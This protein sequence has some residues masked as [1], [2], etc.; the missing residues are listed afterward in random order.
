VTM[1]DQSLLPGQRSGDHRHADAAVCRQA[2]PSYESVVP[3]GRSDRGLDPSVGRTEPNA[4]VSS[5]GWAPSGRTRTSWPDVLIG[6]G[7]PGAR[8]ATWRSSRP[9]PFA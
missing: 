8:R 2:E 6:R 5:A 1:C 9:R 7:D 4:R 3:A